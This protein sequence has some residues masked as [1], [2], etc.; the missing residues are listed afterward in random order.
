MIMIMM[1]IMRK[2]EVERED[3]AVMRISSVEESDR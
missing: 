3:E 1:M 2:R